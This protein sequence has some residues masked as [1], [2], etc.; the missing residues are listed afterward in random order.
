MIDK[1]ILNQGRFVRS[2]RTK[3]YAEAERRA[4][5]W[6]QEK[7]EAAIH[8]KRTRIT[9][10]DASALFLKKE[11]EKPKIQQKKKSTLEAD[12]RDLNKLMPFLGSLYLD[13]IYQDTVDPYIKSLRNKGN[14]ATTINRTLRVLSYVLRLCATSWRD[15]N[16]KPY[17]DTPPKIKQ[18]PEY[19]KKSTQPI[20]YAEEK[21]L[22]NE[23]NNDYKMYWQ[24]AVN[25]GLRQM[26]QATLKW[27]WEKTIPQYHRSAFVIPSHTKQ[28]KNT[29]NGKDFL[30]LLNT[31]AQ[32]IVDA[33]RGK[34]AIYVFPSVGEKAHGRF[35]Q[36]H[37][38]G[39]R[40]RAGL[41]GVITWHSA[42]T[43]FATRLRALKI[44]EEDRA[45]LLGHSKSI[46][47]Q[48]SWASIGHLI[49]CVDRLC[50]EDLSID[51]TMDLQS[52][53]RTTRK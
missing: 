21:V 5:R 42:R 3:D 19:D 28:V 27:E 48:Y 44:S 22:L 39:A 29:K 38:R 36:K 18:L 49:E 10:N 30:V 45:Q 12:I 50:D 6:I 15:G 4:L 32:A 35:N 31:T 23:L 20:E 8:G 7:E 25:T 33:Q 9:F 16:H 52:L 53:F 14:K 51:Q 17:L 37:F 11:M 2:T 43:T 24:F 26:T 41:E 13:Q 1:I 34:N 47:T 46:T 40:Q